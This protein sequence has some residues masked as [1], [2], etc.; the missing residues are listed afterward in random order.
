MKRIDRDTRRLMRLPLVLVAVG[1]AVMIGAVIWNRISCCEGGANI[2]AGMLG[3]LGLASLA[4]GC[5]WGIVTL[6]AVRAG[7]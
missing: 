1:A 5:L 6:V 7:R 3:L 2:G 4:G